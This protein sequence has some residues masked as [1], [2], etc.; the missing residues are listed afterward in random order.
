VST[1]CAVDGIADRQRRT[2]AILA[3]LSAMSLVV[4]DAA[5]V[6]VA[7]PTLS[8]NLAVASAAAIRVVTA[9]QLGL[10]VALLPVAALGESVGLRRVFIAG[11]SL[12]TVGSVLCTLSPTFHWLVAA[13]FVQGIGGAGIMALGIALLRFVVPQHQ[14]GAA[15]GWNALTV[16]L[17]SA[18][19]PTIGASIL[20]IATWPWLFAINLPIGVLA[21]YASHALPRVPGTRRV[22][23]VTSIALSVCSFALLLIGAEFLSSQLMLAGAMLFASGISAHVLIL[24]ERNRVAPLVPLD[25]LR[26]RSFRLSI[27]ASALLFIGQAAGLV[28]LPFHLQ[29][30]FGLTTLE[31]GLYL[32]PWPLTVALAGPLVGKLAQRTSTS[33]L[34]LAGG[35]ILYVGLSGAALIPPKGASLLLPVSM[36]VCGIGFSLFNV[37]NNRNMFLSTP[38]ERSGATGGMQSIARLLG[39]TLGAVLMSGLF[40]AAPFLPAPRLGL[41]L[42]AVLALIAA[43]VSIQRREGPASGL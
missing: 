27:T 16:A 40:H 24:R 2:F 15:I 42:A 31:T 4:L 34:C 26:S 25:L 18:A 32:L 43:L 8:R 21:I 11:V 6:N 36:I 23:D 28:A 35:L 5:I 17:S 41:A 29:R 20:S 3:V 7:L 10:V 13:R 38:L 14:F 19:G 33:T 9:Y 12:F 39:Q 30:T 1:V 22:L 37:A